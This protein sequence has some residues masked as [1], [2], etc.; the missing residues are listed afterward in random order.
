MPQNESI[1]ITVDLTTGTAR[2]AS[3]KSK[4][5]Y[6]VNLNKSF[7]KLSKEAQNTVNKY[8]TSKKGEQRLLE[9]RIANESIGAQSLSMEYILE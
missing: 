1:K 5:Q 2:V 7:S 4:G 3:G 6:A 8:L 9:A